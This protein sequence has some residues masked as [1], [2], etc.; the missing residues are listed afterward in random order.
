MNCDRECEACPQWD[1]CT[2]EAAHEY[3][4]LLVLEQGDETI[5]KACTCHGNIA[6]RVA[7][8]EDRWSRLQAFFEK[9]GADA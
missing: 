1:T 4:A 5:C 9:M 3:R 2:M 6:G 8:L 7:L